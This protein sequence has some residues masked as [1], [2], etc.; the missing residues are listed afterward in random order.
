MPDQR[1]QPAFVMAILAL[2]GVFSL[3]QLVKS[4]D[5]GN[6]PPASE[7][8]ASSTPD[9]GDGEDEPKD[10]D[11]RNLK[12]LVDYLSNGGSP[13]ATKD[14]LARYFS[15]QLPGTNVYCLVVCLPAPVGSVASGRFDEYLDVVQRAI[16]LQG[17][18]LD[19]TLL[20]WKTESSEKNAPADTVT[21]LQLRGE[22]TPIGFET[23]A[24]SQD[25]KDHQPG[26]M[27][28]KHLV[29]QKHDG[30]LTPPSVLLTFLVPE[31]PI[32]G[33]RKHAFLTS[34]RLIDTYFRAYLTHDKPNGTPVLHI[35][36][37]CF[38]SSERSLEL[39]LAGWQPPDGRHYHFRI[40]SSSASLINRDRLQN[41]L[42]KQSSHTVT[43]SSM[44][45]EARD[46]KDGIITYLDKS[47]RYARSNVA[48]LVESNSGLAQALVQDERK[49]GV[50]Q[51]FEL[52]LM[53]PAHDPS[54]LPPSAKKRVVLAE[55]G[56][57]LHFRIFNSDGKLLV[58]KNEQM[59]SDR[60]SNMKAL[61]ARLENL[62]PP[63]HVTKLEK[64][65]V[66]S[67]VMEIFGEEAPGRV[68]LPAPGL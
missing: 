10:S 33:I 11:V 43:F 29:A 4:P 30:A 5:A 38:N 1:K 59:L 16:E 57:K 28:F 47:L 45:H 20:P 31:S 27:V 17:Y 9:S 25:R 62:W 56:G 35:S 34:L 13:P 32:S 2:L 44:V 67:G 51:S 14:A 41:I 48:V 66:L 50:D 6:P 40:I 55:V 46:L 63:H 52:E 21:K 22:D 12:P 24:S 7:S 53:P 15:S 8:S 65:D 58:D 36:A 37:P 39:A 60:R 42:G 54:S 3:P 18:I 49:K 26:L 64:Y 19:R 61:K 68:P 23:T